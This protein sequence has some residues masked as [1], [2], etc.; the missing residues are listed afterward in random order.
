MQ[1]GQNPFTADLWEPKTLLKDTDECCPQTQPNANPEPTAP[2]NAETFRP[3]AENP[4]H[5]SLSTK[6]KQDSGARSG[7]SSGCLRQTPE[8]LG[9]KLIFRIL[10]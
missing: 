9:L 7:C 1:T 2:P 8:V 10:G 3:K 6:K 4:T 5:P